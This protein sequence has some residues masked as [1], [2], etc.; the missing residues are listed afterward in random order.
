MLN[1]IR[2]RKT[3]RLI[4]LY[5]VCLCSTKRTLGLYRLKGDIGKKLCKNIPLMFCD[6]GQ[7]N[8][9]HFGENCMEN[10][11]PFKK[12]YAK[13]FSVHATFHN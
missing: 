12:I 2:R 6:D 11:Y 9:N 8:S 1:Q 4:W 3:R 5:T 10:F 7:R 13:L